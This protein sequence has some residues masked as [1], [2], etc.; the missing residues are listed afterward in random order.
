MTSGHL[1]GPILGVQPT[2]GPILGGPD[3]DL[4]L[5]WAIQAWIWTYFGRYMPG[6]DLILGGQAWICA[7][8]GC[9]DLYLAYFGVPGLI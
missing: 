1:F 3:L 5:F 8:L 6:F 2:V 4:G 7:Y 9:K